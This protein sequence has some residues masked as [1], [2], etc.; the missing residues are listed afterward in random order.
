L[1][2]PTSFDHTEVLPVECSVVAWGRVASLAPLYSLGSLYKHAKARH[3]SPV[4][5]RQIL[6][7]KKGAAHHCPPLC[8]IGRKTINPL[9]SY[10]KP[11]PKSADWLGG[12][13]GGMLCM[14]LGLAHFHTGYSFLMISPKIYLMSGH[15][16]SWFQAYFAPPGGKHA[17]KISRLTGGWG[18]GDALHV[19]W[20]GSFS[21]WL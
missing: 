3:R 17:T 13:G 1:L 10:I 14:W 12:G 9:W 7:N 18:R 16:S 8:W 2:W 4:R 20:L 15:C 5:V 11:P 6:S 19:A 21:H